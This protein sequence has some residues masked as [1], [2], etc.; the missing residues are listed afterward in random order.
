MYAE[1]ENTEW[2]GRFLQ[3][4][5]CGDPV[6]RSSWQLDVWTAK[7][8]VRAAGG[9]AKTDELGSVKGP[10]KNRTEFRT[11]IPAASNVVGERTAIIMKS[12]QTEKRGVFVE[13]QHFRNNR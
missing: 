9:P 3:A 2:D 13:S 8:A 5:A 11:Y 6:G 12:F 10:A 4:E 1:G 7:G